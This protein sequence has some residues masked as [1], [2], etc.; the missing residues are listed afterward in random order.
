MSASLPF[1]CLGGDVAIV[2]GVGSGRAGGGAPMIAG[3]PPRAAAAA[4]MATPDKGPVA[5]NVSMSMHPT[6]P[7]LEWGHGAAG[8]QRT[9]AQPPVGLHLALAGLQPALERP[10]PHLQPALGGL[11]V[12]GCEEATTAAMQ[13]V[14]YRQ[15]PPGALRTQLAADLATTYLA[16]LS[17]GGRRCERGCECP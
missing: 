17:D 7:A 16:Q 2:G 12:G 5:T 8:E 14:E 15:M 4:A 6:R 3:T 9:A 13:L 10:F 1:A 11:I